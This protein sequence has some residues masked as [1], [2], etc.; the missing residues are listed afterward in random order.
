MKQSAGLSL[1]EVV[2]ALAILAVALGG[3]TALLLSSMKQDLSAGKRTQ[4]VQILNF[5]GRL[6]VSGD[7]RLLVEPN[8]PRTW[9][10]GKLRDAFPELQSSAGIN[11]PDLYKV[12][13]ENKG[14]PTE[15]QNL[16]VKLNAYRIEVCWQTGGQTSCVQGET[17]SS[18]PSGEDSPPPLPLIN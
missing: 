7:P 16:G 18:P 4:A 3:F 5:L 12:T 10:Y 17:L 11:N 2:I 6:Q 13:V 8:H 14:T 9:D 15:V 1:I